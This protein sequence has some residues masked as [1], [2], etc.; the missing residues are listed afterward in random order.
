M[1]LYNHAD[2]SE[3]GIRSDH[4]GRGKDVFL[5]PDRIQLFPCRQRTSVHH[6]RS[7]RRYFEYRGYKVEFVQNSLTLTT[8]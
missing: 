4:A 3:G 2:P 1:K 5:R 6:F 7:L 8:R